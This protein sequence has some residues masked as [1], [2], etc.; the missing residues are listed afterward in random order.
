MRPSVSLDERYLAFNARTGAVFAAYPQLEPLRQVVFKHF[1][2]R[3]RA[4]DWWQRVKHWLRPLHRRAHTR[5]PGRAEVLLWL[6][7]RRE[8]IVEALLPVHRELRRRGGRILLVSFGGPSGLP[9]SHR[10][11]YP[12][13]AIPPA[14]AREAWEAL[15]E[16]EDGLRD[17]AL[18]RSFYRA[19]AMLAG[20]YDELHTLVEVTAPATVLCA[21]TQAIG[22]AALMVTARRQ[23][24]RTLVLQHGLMQPVYAPLSADLMLTWGPSSNDA[25]VTFG[26]SRARLRVVGS[27][28]H[29]ALERPE[30]SAARAALLQAL[31][32]PARP[33][34]VF[35][36]NGNDLERNGDAPA[37]CARWL[38]AVATAYVNELNVVVRLHPNEDGALYRRARHLTVTRGAV[39]LATTLAGCDCIGSLC[40]TAMYDGLLYGK[41][42]WHFHQDEWPPL[43]DNWQRGLAHRVESERQLQDLVERSLSGDPPGRVEERLVASVFANRGRAARTVA[44]VVSVSDRGEHLPTSPLNAP[45]TP[46]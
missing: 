37:H 7:G 40:S 29:D 44:D 46:C 17:G 6:E 13:R 21:S 3:R 23:G 4:D 16:C 45:A 8:V 32:L 31:G 38:E 42:V 28:R 15:C 34:F 33:T 41:P 26:V 20:L 19:T 11:A 43:A 24:A 9:T 25:L 36:S 35:F 5:V 18:R 22:G 39:R 27:P 2:V 14:W 10:F 30:H 12:A 1:L